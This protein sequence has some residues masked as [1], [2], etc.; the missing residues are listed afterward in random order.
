[1]RKHIIKGITAIAALAALFAGTG[2]RITAANAIVLGVSIAWLSLVAF[3][4]L[5]RCRHE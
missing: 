4:T 5:R 1:M 3:A 2:D